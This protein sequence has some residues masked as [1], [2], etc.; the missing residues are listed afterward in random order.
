MG[1]VSIITKST[2]SM[3]RLA[4]V[5][6]FSA[7][8]FALHAQA[9]GDS[10][11]LSNGAMTRANMVNN[12]STINSNWSF[13]ARILRI[14]PVYGNCPSGWRSVSNNSSRYIKEK[15]A[16][17]G[18]YSSGKLVRTERVNYAHFTSGPDRDWEDHCWKYDTRTVTRR[19]T[20][21][22]AGNPWDPT[23]V[24][25]SGTNENYYTI[26]Q[27]RRMVGPKDNGGYD[28]DAWEDVGGTQQRYWR[29]EFGPERGPAPGP[30]DCGGPRWVVS[31]TY[32]PTKV[33]IVC[34]Y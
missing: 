3:R 12:Q 2:K 24:P 26:Q 23:Y 18:Y 14:E 10:S 34:R 20:G 25:G 15:I 9:I 22:G 4:A 33:V 32:T 17:V 5:L 7:T 16:V 28:Y 27:R 8:P 29:G 6:C 30:L 1:S 21:A 19:S 11:H 13:D 31:Y